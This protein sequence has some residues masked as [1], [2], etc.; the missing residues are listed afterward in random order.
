M[1][2]AIEVCR[3]AGMKEHVLHFL[4]SRRGE[5]A[6]RVR[7]HG[8]KFWHT[9]CV[10]SDYTVYTMID[11]S[12]DPTMMVYEFMMDMDWQDVKYYKI[13]EARLAVFELFEFVQAD[14]F[15][16]MVASLTH[17]MLK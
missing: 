14:K 13:L 2:F 10:D 17:G 9:H 3:R 12:C 4:F 6:R 5:G 1:A 8:W 11:P 16:K 15:P 7:L